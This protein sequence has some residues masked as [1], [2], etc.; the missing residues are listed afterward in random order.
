MVMKVGGRVRQ[1]RNDRFNTRRIILDKLSDGLPHPVKEFFPLIGRKA[2]EQGLLGTWMRGL[3]LRTKSPIYDNELL[4][5]GRLETIHHYRRFHLYLMRPE[6]F[7]D[8]C[9]LVGKMEFVPYAK[10][11][12]DTRGGN[13]SSKSSKIIAFLKQNSETPTA[14]SHQ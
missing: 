3:I 2:A 13:E 5:K 6:N 12:L 8:K 4:S 14:T 7:T 11:C 10:K 9:V 1:S